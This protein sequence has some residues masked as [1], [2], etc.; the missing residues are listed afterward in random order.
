MQ[1]QELLAFSWIRVLRTAILAG[2][3]LDSSLRWKALSLSPLNMMLCMSHFKSHLGSSILIPCYVKYQASLESLMFF[4]VIVGEVETKLLSWGN[5]ILVVVS[6]TMSLPCLCPKK[7]KEKGLPAN[8]F[9]SPLV[10]QRETRGFPFF[11]KA[12][13]NGAS[14]TLHL[15]NYSM[16]KHGIWTPE[17]SEILSR[18]SWNIELF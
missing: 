8:Y 3:T 10:P 4:W 18:V 9:P 1:W 15:S 14:V 7:L 2:N 13:G 12:I 16:A 6:N 17:G 5:N 11:L